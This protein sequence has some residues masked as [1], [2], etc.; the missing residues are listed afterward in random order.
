MTR[1]SGPG[2]RRDPDAVRTLP[3]YRGYIGAIQV[4]LLATHVAPPPD[5]AAQ[6]DRPGCGVLPNWLRRSRS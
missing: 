6:D 3:V 1:R 5:A 2:A 4:V